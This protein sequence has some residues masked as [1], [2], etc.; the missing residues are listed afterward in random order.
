MA[1]TYL[2]QVA[3]APP[4][5]EAATL[6][7]EAAYRTIPVWPPHKQFLVVAAGNDLFIDHVF[8]FGL[9]TAGGVQGHVAD[10]TVDILS[11]YDL[12]PIKKWVDDH[13]FFRFPDGGGVK[14][15]LN[16]WSGGA[17]LQLVRCALYPS[18]C[19]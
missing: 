17:W 7:I 6:D 4:G 15:M 19:P 8:P 11:S 16:G 2:P 5:T 10:A 3:T 13:T 9:S 1:L 18:T 12:G 14:T